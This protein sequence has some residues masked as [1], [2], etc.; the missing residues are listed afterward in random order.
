MTKASHIL[1]AELGYDSI[2]FQFKWYDSGPIYRFMEM[3]DVI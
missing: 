2:F 1:L 3:S